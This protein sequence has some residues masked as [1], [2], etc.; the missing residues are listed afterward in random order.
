MPTKPQ[1][2]IVGPGRLGTALARHLDR[3]G[4]K[5]TEVV[6]H[7][8]V[9]KRAVRLLAQAVGAKVS[10]IADARLNA[11]V[12]WFCVPD[13]QIA[14]AARDLAGKVDWSCKIAFHSSGALT[15]NEL[16]VLR[17]NGTSAA[18]VHPL[19]TFVAG[20]VPALQGVPF[21]VEGDS[22]AVRIATKIV[23]DLGGEPFNI[24]PAH[25]V[26]YHAWGAFT[27]PLLIALL[28]TA[29]QVARS[30]GLSA[31]QA[32]K[33]MLPIL[34]QTI[35]NYSR[36]GP[37]GAFSGPLVRGDAEIVRKHLQVLKRIPKARKAYI[38]L[39]S[40]AL[41]GLPVQNK[42]RLKRLLQLQRD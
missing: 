5:I 17:R 26:A 34:R 22:G 28:V 13:Q 10:R 35:E 40:A 42:S 29:E 21:A 23:H 11:N 6:H 37:A 19:M 18:S 14:A 2:A 31:V 8:S 12:I 1:I 3:A 7:G 9:P 4:Y 36:L 32:R 41:D 16:N 38:N 15:S 24:E 39:A 27:S 30:A 33:K 25:K 20:A